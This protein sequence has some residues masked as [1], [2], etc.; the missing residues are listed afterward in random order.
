MVSYILVFVCLEKRGKIIECKRHFIDLLLMPL[1]CHFGS[2]LSFPST[3]T[4]VCL[5]GICSVCVHTCVLMT[6]IT[7]T[8][9]LV[10][11]PRLVNSQGQRMKN[12]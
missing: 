11:S 7:K 10:S 12:P 5:V 1:Q 9:N 4:L 2:P 8:K 3:G 6:L